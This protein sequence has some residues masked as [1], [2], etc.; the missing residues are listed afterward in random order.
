M[1]GICPVSTK[2]NPIQTIQKVRKPKRTESIDEPTEG[3]I[4]FRN[5]FKVETFHRR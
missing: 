3:E 5:E 4:E 2:G 1:L